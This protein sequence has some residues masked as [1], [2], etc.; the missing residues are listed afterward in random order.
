MNN[1]KSSFTIQDLEILSGIKAHTIRIWEKRYDILDPDRLNRNIRVYNLKDL[2]KILNLSFLQ[3][4][5]F[6]ISF[7]AT[8]SEEQLAEEILKLSEQNITKDHY[9]NTIIMSM[10]AFDSSLFE[11]VY[12]EQIKNS[13]FENIFIDTYIP[14]LNHIGVLWQ[15]DSLRPV[16]EHFISNLIYQK[17]VLNSALIPITDNSSDEVYILFLPEGEIHEIGLL[18]LDYY[19]KSKGKKTIYIGKSIPFENLF[20]IKEQFENINWITYFLIDKTDEEKSNFVS[21]FEKL[22]SKTDKAHI[23]GHVWVDFPKNKLSKQIA[24]HKGYESLMDELKES[25]GFCLTSNVIC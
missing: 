13:T 24:F 11:Q 4:H 2:Q 25:F 14:L 1:I 3:K 18:F 17:I 8:L 9:V 20:Y 7:L 19:L 21:D 6:K 10:Y 5:N 23:I 12:Q 22:I 15:T 16:H